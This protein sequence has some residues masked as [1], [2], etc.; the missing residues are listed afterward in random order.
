MAL[1]IR[2]S[3]NAL[4]QVPVLQMRDA[5]GVRRAIHEGKIR[6]AGN[7]LLVFLP[8]VDGGV[9]PPTIGATQGVFD[10][11]YV[12]YTSSAQI[13][14]VN[15]LPPITY[16]WTRQSGSTDVREENTYSQNTRFFSH[17]TE[18]FS[19][20]ATF[21]GTATDAAGR[22]VEGTIEVTITTLDWD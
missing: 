22:T 8:A 15:M 6:D 13:W 17:F 2:D 14:N 12:L 21:K 9:T 18:D 19:R 7:A 1:Q 11:P 4:R 16:A 20:T 10:F 5:G 3:D